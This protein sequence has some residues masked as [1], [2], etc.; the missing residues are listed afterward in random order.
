M[1]LKQRTQ[2]IVTADS[3]TASLCIAG[4]GN[5][6]VCWAKEGALQNVWLLPC[7]WERVVTF[8]CDRCQLW[9]ASPLFMLCQ[10]ELQRNRNPTYH[11][12]LACEDI[13][14]DLLDGVNQEQINGLQRSTGKGAASSLPDG[15][16]G[17]RTLSS[18]LNLP[19]HK[20]MWVWY[21]SLLLLFSATHSAWKWILICSTGEL[22]E[23]GG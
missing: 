9:G 18:L 17:Y 20:S 5:D 12:F 1:R 21:Y 4:M 22:L 11:S 8:V 3:V 23:P 14:S 2:C 15:G 13:G 19:F 10:G 7:C 6:W 16:E